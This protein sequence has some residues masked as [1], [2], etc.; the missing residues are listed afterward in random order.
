[1][2]TC[3]NEGCEREERQDGRCILHC[4]K[5][6]YATD[7]GKA[8]FL[9]LFHEELINYIADGVVNS[10]SVSL[11]EKQQVIRLL[12][13]ENI[14]NQQSIAGRIRRNEFTFSG[15]YFPDKVEEQQP[16]FNSLLRDL[17]DIAFSDCHFSTK[18]LNKGDRKYRYSNCIFHG[19]L[20]ISNPLEPDNQVSIYSDC[21]FHEDVFL[22]GGSGNH[23]KLSGDLFSNCNFN[24]KLKLSN[25]YFEKMIF[26]NRDDFNS[27]VQELKIDNCLVSG[28]FELNR[29][30]IGSLEIVDSVF[31]DK[32]EL[33]EEVVNSFYLLNTNFEKL[34]DFYE[35]TFEKFEIR[36]CIFDDF[37]V[38]EKCS[39]GTTSKSTNGVAK[40]T[41][42]TFKDNVNFRSTDFRSG[43][44][45]Q[46][47]NLSSVPNFLGTAIDPKN[48]VRE[49]FR[50]VKNSF[51]NVGNY[52]EANTHFA[53]EMDKYREELNETDNFWEHLVY[54]FNYG[55]SNFGQDYVTP[56][57]L[58]FIISSFYF[59]LTIGYEN[60]FYPKY[61]II[62]MSISNVANGFAINII[63]FGAFLKEGME[64]IS[65]L[66]YIS[67][68]VLL[69]HLI[70]ALKRHTKR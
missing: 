61:N 57:K 65:L 48:T 22:D 17:D 23:R 67:T 55:V 7:A 47:I 2:S 60:D 35:K 24:S 36:K 37:V 4:E 38:F 8:G 64:F 52:I 20:D 27:A 51:D 33:K 12:Q 28:K 58:I 15:V 68:S 44:D 31:R 14:L 42:A 9:E 18:T 63:P 10:K 39:F 29:H 45:L 34:V 21:T 66:I 41:Y 43:I 3:T 6:D 54:K 30:T 26:S 11:P 50:I 40:F 69:W 70:V 16:D 46:N 25:M 1:M 19:I 56:I 53:H 13:G 59:F 62:F 32:F 5:S 49:S